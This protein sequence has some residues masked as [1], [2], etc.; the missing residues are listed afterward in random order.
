[1]SEDRF[2]DR[3]DKIEDIGIL[4]ELVCREYNL[5]DYLDTKIIEIG[6]E[7]VNVVITTSTGKY[8]MKVFSNDRD[9]KEASEVIERAHVAAENG[10][11]SPRVFEN[12]KGSIISYIN[13]N[14][15]RFRLALMEFIDG[16]NFYE[17]GR[18]ATDEELL[19]ISDLASQ[20]GNINYKPNFIYDTWAISSFVSEFE[21]KQQFLSE[22]EIKSIRPIYER[23]K[24]FNYQA[25]PK[26]FTHGDI[27]LTNLLQDKKGEYWVVDYSVSNYTARLNEIV[28]AASDFGI[29]E[30]KKQESERRIKL[31]FERWAKKVN[32]T[33]FERKAFEMLF[34]VQNAIYVLNPSYQIS[35]GNSSEENKM[36]LGLGQFG[37]T[38]D[39][40]MSK[41]VER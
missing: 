2:L 24:K 17:L 9:D 3:I 28:V 21:K 7:D 11:K 38:L 32:A 12:S 19:K 33:D 13:Y 41:E 5:G 34:R 26:S 15:S 20:F 27:I 25:L 4:S 1:M 18:K 14:N 31:M 40:D 22:E 29:V 39:V 23:L 35:I 6:Y 37:L 10:V 30:G 16:S 36:F 8:F